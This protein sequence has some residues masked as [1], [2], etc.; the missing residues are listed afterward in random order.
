MKFQPEKTDATL[1]TAYDA[2]GIHIGVERI[3]KSLVLGSHGERFDWIAARF[4]DLTAE[5][6]ER[7]GESKPE[8][9]IFG[10]GAKLR[11]VHPKL[12]SSLMQARIGVETMDTPA[13]CRTYNILAGEGRHVVGAF[14]IEAKP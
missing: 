11:F 9:I 14:L 5:H 13:A 8:L 10:S 6:F 3:E 2:G 7:L 4:E 12:L 1:I